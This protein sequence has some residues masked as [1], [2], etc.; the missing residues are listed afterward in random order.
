MRKEAVVAYFEMHLPGRMKE[1]T[2][3]ESGYLVFG[4]WFISCCFRPEAIHSSTKFIV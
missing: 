2:K 4:P 1:T 3:D